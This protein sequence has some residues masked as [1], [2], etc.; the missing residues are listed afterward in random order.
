MEAGWDSLW[1]DWGKALGAMSFASEEEKT[2]TG[3]GFWCIKHE[4]SRVIVGAGCLSA[5]A[6]PF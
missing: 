5:L 2:I 6:S 1:A 4:Y 3:G